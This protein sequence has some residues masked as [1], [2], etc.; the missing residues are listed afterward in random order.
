MEK[1]ALQNHPHWNYWAGNNRS[2]I[3]IVTSTETFIPTEG[4]VAP[5]HW[6]RGVLDGEPVNSPFLDVK[7]R[8]PPSKGK[9]QGLEICRRNFPPANIF[10]RRIFLPYRFGFFSCKPECLDAKFR[11]NVL[12]AKKKPRQKLKKMCFFWSHWIPGRVLGQNVVRGCSAG[13]IWEKVRNFWETFG[14]SVLFRVS[15]FQKNEF[16]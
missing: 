14:I 11:F 13:Q 8:Y 4:K 1:I 9:R 2:F 3:S 15:F 10:C 12:F 6:D 7:L 16:H 5:G